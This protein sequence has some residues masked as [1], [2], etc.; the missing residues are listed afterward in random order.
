MESI[1]ETI[2]KFLTARKGQFQYG[3]PLARE[4]AKLAECKEETAGRACRDLAE[5]GKIER[6][7]IRV[8]TK[9]GIKKIVIYRIKQ[10]PI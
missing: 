7:W 2:M 5:S 8:Q 9:R 3:G 6:D 4:I 10:W 1:S